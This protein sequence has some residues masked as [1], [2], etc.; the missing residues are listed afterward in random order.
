MKRSDLSAFF[1]FPF[2]TLRS[3][4]ISIETTQS[5][6]VHVLSRHRHH[7]F[8][9]NLGQGNSKMLKI[10]QQK[11]SS[12]AQT[13]LLAQFPGVTSRK[14]EVTPQNQS[15]RWQDR[16]LKNTWAAENSKFKSNSTVPNAISLSPWYL[17]TCK[18]RG[19]E[20]RERLGQSLLGRT[21]PWNGRSCSIEWT[22]IYLVNFKT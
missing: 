2:Q 6:T 13:Q 1:F 18:G 7:H 21:N 12:E 4:F 20:G 5:H 15:S 14:L 19:K 11:E 16:H 9:M 17:F 22:L 10:W 3:Y 8:H